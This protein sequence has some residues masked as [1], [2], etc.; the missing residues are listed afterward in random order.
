MDESRP[1]ASLARRGIFPLALVALLVVSALAA[2]SLARWLRVP[3]AAPAAKFPGR[4]LR[5]WNKPDLVLVLTGQQHGYLLP[6]GCSSPQVGGMERRYNFLKMLEDNGWPHVALDLG[7]LPQRTGPAGLPN[8]QGLTKYIYSMKGLKAMNYGAVTLGEYEV[9]LGL[10]NVLTNFALN[11]PDYKVV[12][13]NLIDAETH[14]PD[15]TVPWKVLDVKGL[16]V[17]V[18]S[19]AG[20]QVAMRIKALTKSEKAPRFAQTAATLKNV[21]GQMQ[22]AKVDIPILLYQGPWSRN[23]GQRPPTEG[24]AC[25]EAFPEF[26]IVL[27]LS[28]E[29]DPP[30]R[31]LDVKTRNGTTSQIILLGHKGKHLG[32]VGIWKTGKP[33]EPYAFRYER[34]E[35]TEDFQTPKDKEKDHPIIALMEEYTRELRDKNFLERYGQVKHPLQILDEDQP[36]KGLRNIVPVT[37]VGSKACEKCHQHAH[38]YDVWAKSKHSHAYKTLVDAKRPSNRQ[39]DPECIVCHTVGFGYQSGFVSATKTPHLENVGCESCHGPCSVHVKNSTN[40]VWQKRINPWKHIKNPQAKKSAIQDMCV[41]CHD[42][43]NDVTW[44]NEGFDKKWRG[45]KEPIEHMT[46]NPGE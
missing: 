42:Q 39:F 17:G 27:C 2:T 22:N 23:S 34:V 21:V 5:G 25:A 35:M 37:Y 16:R 1:P 26:P 43:D 44:T 19:V 7:D 4:V 30:A 36:V 6:C 45:G 46:P 28:S 9:N 41:K 38:A 3:P 18:A 24:V 14:Y 20:P 31:P 40:A 29:D 10:F 13:S 12:A 11:E 32:V 8:L 15:M 33:A